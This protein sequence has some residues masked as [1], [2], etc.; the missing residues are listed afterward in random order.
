MSRQPLGG[1]E[2]RRL[3]GSARLCCH[4]SLA[5][6]EKI[7]CEPSDLSE[8]SSVNQNEKQVDTNRRERTQLLLLLAIVNESRNLGCRSIMF[9]RSHKRETIVP[10]ALRSS[11]QE[12]Q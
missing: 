8:I 7:P 4:N 5:Y 12:Q 10:R 9:A 6:K 2:P 3:D 1:L 11:F